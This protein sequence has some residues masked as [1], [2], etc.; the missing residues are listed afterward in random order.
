M[1]T[2]TPEAWGFPPR[3]AAEIA[4]AEWRCRIVPGSTVMQAL[5]ELADARDTLIVLAGELHEKATAIDKTIAAQDQRLQVYGVP[6]ADL[7]AM[8]RE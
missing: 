4:L 1:P 7:I 3:T 8:V 6:V 2:L 5:R